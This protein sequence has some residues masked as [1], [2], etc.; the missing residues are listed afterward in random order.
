[1]LFFFGGGLRFLRL[2][3][4][5]LVLFA[6]VNIAEILP[7]ELRLDLCHLLLEVLVVRVVQKLVYLFLTH[8]GFLLEFFG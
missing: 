6:E 8:F 4:G 7:I 1:M 3:L 5:W 2:P